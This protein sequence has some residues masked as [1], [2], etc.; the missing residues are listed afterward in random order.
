MT[1]KGHKNHY[2]IKLLRG[3][4]VAIHLKDNRVI[5]KNGLD[6][7][8][9]KSEKEEW[10][11]T[12]IPY[13]KI[14]ISGRGYVSTDAIKLLSEKNVN[15]ILTDTFGNLISNMNNVMS[16]T[17][18]TGYRIGQYDT[19]RDPDKVLYLR[20]WILTEKLNSQINFLKSL[21]REYLQKGISQ[22]E[23]Y[24]KQV[25]N[26]TEYRNF[27]TTESR[28]GHIYF[29]N[30]AKL[31][32]P[33]YMF[34]SR[35][36]GGIRLSNRYASDV[37]NALL[38]YGY[39]VLA[40]EIAKFVNGLGLDP[41][42]GFYHRTHTSFQALVY[43]LIEPF[44]WL[45]EYSVYKVANHQNY[46]QSIKKNEYAWTREGKVVLDSDLIK[47]FLE[48][49]ERK[50]QAERPYKFKHG[51]KMSNGMSMCQEITIVKITIQNLADYCI[52]MI[53]LIQN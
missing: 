28:C 43:D 15:V 10:F 38:N 41:Y 50:F 23:L 40:G 47:R 44:R 36:G 9:N 11:V 5:L 3:Y 37:I 4:G 31:F 1:L 34:E 42:Y 27:L 17:T 8:S 48:I 13:E 39:T 16:S 21:E 12:Q 45:V 24:L 2:N 46:D 22:L 26:F 6:V 32:D 35:H 53:N 25:E 18:A 49:L 30:Y 29:N 33:K 14:V 20:K 52:V 7:L 19:F 51:L